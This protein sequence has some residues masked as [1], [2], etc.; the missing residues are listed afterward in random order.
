MIALQKADQNCKKL[1]DR[2]EKGELNETT[3]IMLEGVLH[4]RISDNKQT[5]TTIVLPQVLI[6]P[7]LH[8]A[9]EVAGHNGS[10]RTY[11]ALRRRYYWKGMKKQIYKHCKQCPNCRLINL[12]I[13][14]HPDLHF[15]IPTMPMQQVSM[16][17][18]GQ[19]HPPSAKGNQYALTCICMLTGFVFCVPIPNKDMETVLKAYINKI[20][21]YAGGSITILTDNG[22]EFKN[23]L[24]GQVAKELGV[25]HKIEPPPFH[26]ASNGRIEGFHKF[27]KACLSKHITE[28]MEW[29]DVT[30][31]A[32]AA[33]NFFPNEH[34]KESPFFLMYG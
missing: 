11:M 16:D 12:E 17:L 13:V 32:T 9:H 33:Y 24:F 21:A 29:D 3:Y 18:I 14:K 30:D 23:K 22:T 7:A 2:Y 1:I 5:F 25:Q 10:T 20:Y 6:E 8:L 26:P 19:F 34:S 31:L 15:K 27:L 4:R 28:H